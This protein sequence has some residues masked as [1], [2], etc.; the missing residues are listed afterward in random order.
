MHFQRFV[1]KIFVSYMNNT[2]E[3]TKLIETRLLKISGRYRCYD[4]G[5]RIGKRNRVPKTVEI[6]E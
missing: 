6:H 4:H 2:L 1:G 3:I 5:R